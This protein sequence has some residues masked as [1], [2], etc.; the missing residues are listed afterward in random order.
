M[1]RVSYDAIEPNWGLPAR[2]AFP[3]SAAPR[4]SVSFGSR[5]TL[6]RTARAL[7]ARQETDLSLSP[8]LSLISP[9]PRRMRTTTMADISKA[10]WKNTR[11]DSCAAADGKVDSAIDKWD[12]S[13]KGKD[14][15]KYTKEEAFSEPVKAISDFLIALQQAE[16]ACKA[17]NQNDKAEATKVKATNDLIKDWRTQI[18]THQ[19]SLT[20]ALPALKQHLKDAKKALV[21][22]FVK[23]RNDFVNVLKAHFTMVQKQ[24]ARAKELLEAIEKCEAGASKTAAR[25]GGINSYKEVA[26]KCSGELDGIQVL[27]TRDFDNLLKNSYEEHRHESALLTKWQLIS[28]DVTPH[29]SNTWKEMETLRAD[30][31]KGIKTIEASVQKADIACNNI[32]SLT[33]KDEDKA[34]HYAEEA[35]KFADEAK[36]TLGKMQ[37]LVDNSSALKADERLAFVHNAYKLALQG[38]KKDPEDG[39]IVQARSILQKLTDNGTRIEGFSEQIKVYA[40]LTQSIPANFHDHAKVKAQLDRLHTA[41]N[42]LKLLKGNFEQGKPKL[43]NNM[44]SFITEMENIKKKKATVKT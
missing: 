20:T 5:A 19:T 9:F 18:T 15:T 44:N 39:M 3:I 43:E 34:A 12:A 29:L 1:A 21:D 6:L 11:H 26:D 2:L 38:N 27:A 33:K 13:C 32:A 14:P 4:A 25:G 17:K 35:K 41:G 36:E 23:Y 28:G 31:D 7:R 40:K 10:N 30:I 22:K 37:L 24:V 42:D 8:L 16:S